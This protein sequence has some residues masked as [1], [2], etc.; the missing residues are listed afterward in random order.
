MKAALIGAL[1]LALSAAATAGTVSD[2]F[3]G[4]T[5]NCGFSMAPPYSACDVIGELAHYDIQGAEL[6]AGHSWVSVSLLFNFG[7][8]TLA[9]FNDSGILL[10]AGDILF[11]DPSDP[12]RT[13]Y[14]DLGNH[15]SQF[16]VYRFGIALVA[17]DGL[18]P[19]DLYQI[20]DPGQIQTADSLLHN[21]GYY[22]R[23]NVP[24]WM[25]SSATLEA[26]GTGVAVTPFGDGTSNGLYRATVGFVPTPEFW[27]MTSSSHT[28]GIEWAVAICANDV[29]SGEV[30]THN[31]EPGTMVML[32]GGAG[33][34]GLGKWRLRAR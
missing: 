13:T 19:G 2:P 1:A 20:A 24:V 34:L 12:A 33:L 17:H 9:N 11:F 8:G 31:P 10:S 16:P 30:A 18:N 32:L 25:P 6:D 22:Y 21:T 26:T 14:T 4:S 27:G 15:A 5:S 28:L 3:G 29:L 7:N 23:R